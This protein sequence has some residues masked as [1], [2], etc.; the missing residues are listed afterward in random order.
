MHDFCFN[1]KS[2]SDKTTQHNSWQWPSSSLKAYCAID[3]NR[4]H[5]SR[6]TVILNQTTNNQILRGNTM[7]RTLWLIITFCLLIIPSSRTF[8]Q[9]S[10]LARKVHVGSNAIVAIDV[11]AVH[12]SPLAEKEG[13]AK[14]LDEA[15]VNRAVFLPPEAKQLL[16]ASHLRPDRDFEQA[17]EVAVMSLSEPPSIRAIA[18]AEGGYADTINGMEAAWSPSDAYIVKLE[19]KVMGIVAPA[20]RQGVSRWIDEVRENRSLQ[21]SSYLRAALRSVSDKQQVVL[22]IDLK[23]AAEPH[24]IDD[25]LKSAEFKSNVKTDELAETLASIRGATIQISIG[26]KATA[27]TQIDFDK[28]VNMS[29]GLAKQLVLGAMQNL[30]AEL[31]DLADH[32]FSVTSKAINIDGTLTSSSLRRLFS[33]LEVPT[34]KFSSLKD[35]SFDS[36]TGSAS[37]MPKNSK[38]YFKSVRTLLDDLRG[39][40]SKQDTRGGQDAVW[41]ERY[42]RKIDRLPILFVDE[43][44]L[45]YGAATAET[46]RNMAGARKGAGLK[47]GSAKSGVRGGYSNYSYGYGGIGYTAGSRDATARRNQ[48]NRQYQNQAT[49]SK[50]TGWREIENATASIRRVMTGRYGIEF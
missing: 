28:T 15:Y 38:T 7:R 33:L 43:E 1:G 48:I 13:W 30:G 19:E 47:A 26:K 50:V 18:R 23:D 29:T 27:H 10:E 12:A 34:T 20:H 3:L 2:D 45:A 35:E 42:A 36:E 44:L 6:G 24:R 17:W 22:A 39:D 16:I 21:M 5:E 25:R 14:R 49:Q 32:K 4:L 46:L 40:R 9:F 37:D 41:M 8:A 31:T 11:E